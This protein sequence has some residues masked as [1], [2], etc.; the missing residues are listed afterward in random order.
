GKGDGQDRI[1]YST[2]GVSTKIGTLQ[3]KD[4]VQP[5][6]L[7]FKQ[8]YGPYGNNTSLE[9]SIAG[10][11]DK[12][13][14][15]GFFAY[16]NPAGSINPVQQLRFAD[17]TTWDLESITSAVFAN[18]ADNRTDQLHEKEK[19]RINAS[20]LPGNSV[21]AEKFPNELIAIDGVSEHLATKP[22]A[23]GDPL[24]SLEFISLKPVA[25]SDHPLIHLI[26]SGSSLSVDSQAHLLTEA[27]AQ[28]AISSAI[29]TK[30]YEPGPEV[31]IT[32]IGINWQ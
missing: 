3:F 27:M 29:E 25:I 4:G 18:A 5:S 7:K 10:S 30:I 22:F 12:I 14:I 21:M 15:D 19:L 17:G 11:E 6:E 2:D 9:V 26:S 24:E 23:A 20:S 8:V 13:T 28:F 32:P 16:D 1:E 31:K